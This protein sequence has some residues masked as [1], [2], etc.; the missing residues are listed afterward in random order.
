[1]SRDLTIVHDGADG[2]IVVT[3][4]LTFCDARVSGRDVIIGG[5]FAGALAF[6]FALERGVRALIAHD[7]GVGKDGAGISG[8]PFADT[9]GV[10]AAAVETFSARI[11]D[12][13]SIAESGVIGHVNTGASALG[14]RPGQRARD[15]ASRLLAAPP[16]TA[17]PTPLVDRE[18]R[19]IATIP[20]GRVVLLSSMG[21][22]QADNAGDVLIAGSHGG[23]V[24]VTRLLE[25]RPL[26]AVFNDAGMAKDASGIDG[27]RVLDGAGVAAVAV[28]AMSARIGDPASAW[29]SGVLSTVNATAA[30]IGVLPGMTARAAALALLAALSD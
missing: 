7:A 28:S 24:N 23:R 8:L 26:A 27:L 20:P 13:A 17:A 1:V 12:G 15:A 6:G 14:V 16:G 18:P 9:V 2:R 21:F 10:P 5:S 19:V 22:A 30:R 29:E 25:I 11:G 3:D 4:S